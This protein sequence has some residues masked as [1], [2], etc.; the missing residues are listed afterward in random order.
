MW[1]ARAPSAGRA[2]A[3]PCTSAARTAR[4]ASRGAS[5]PSD[6]PRPA[7]TR[8]SYRLLVCDLDGTL[9]DHGTDLD[10]ALVDGLRRARER[11]LIVSI[12]TG[13]MPPGVDRYRDELVIAHAPVDPLFYRDDLLYCL[14]ESFA[15]RSYSEHQSV[16]LEV[17]DAPGDFLRMS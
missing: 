6:R 9:L 5:A 1:C 2:A 10:L 17:I 4:P 8:V 12:A 15:T 7:P 13:R 11:G 3:R 14:A 16:P